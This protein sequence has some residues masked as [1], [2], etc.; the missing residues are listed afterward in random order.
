MIMA[1]WL[2]AVLMKFYVKTTTA[3]GFEV[4][5]YLDRCFLATFSRKKTSFGCSK[6]K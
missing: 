2:E 5:E 4:R 1:I 3:A 6:E